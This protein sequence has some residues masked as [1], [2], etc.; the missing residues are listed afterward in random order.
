M[1]TNSRKRRFGEFDPDKVLEVI[2]DD[3]VEAEL[4]AQA[5]S[6]RKANQP[7]TFCDVTLAGKLIEKIKE[8]QVAAHR[9][10]VILCAVEV[11]QAG[12]DLGQPL[13][14]ACITLYGTGDAY[15]VLKRSRIGDLIRVRKA[16]RLYFPVREQKGRKWLS[17]F[18]TGRCWNATAWHTGRWAKTDNRDDDKDREQAAADIL[19]SRRQVEQEKQNRS[20][21]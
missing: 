15:R 19:A 21:W 1:T 12:M 9:P 18:V 6:L 17:G 11:G 4:A 3:V 10:H 5:S 20:L 16:S 14:P 8:F 2:P 13:V 7:E